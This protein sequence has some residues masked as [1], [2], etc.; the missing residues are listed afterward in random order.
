MM[1]EGR[2]LGRGLSALIGDEVAT[3]SS[4]DTKSS[5]TLPVAF[6]RPNRFQPR[7]TFAEDELADLT[8][9]IREKG[10]LQPIL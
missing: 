7:K 4:R 5:R 9:S 10:V 8:N 6:L 3:T 2:G 1:A